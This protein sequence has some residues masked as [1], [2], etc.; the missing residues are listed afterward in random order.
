LVYEIRIH[1]FDLIKPVEA[2]VT[3][4]LFK[5]VKTMSQGLLLAVYCVKS[6]REVFAVKRRV[7]FVTSI[8]ESLCCGSLCWKF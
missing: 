5:G 3:E 8:A 2:N 6:L 4:K 1:Q 7:D